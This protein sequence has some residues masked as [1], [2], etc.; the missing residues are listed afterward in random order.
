MKLADWLVLG[1]FLALFGLVVSGGVPENMFVLAAGLGLAFLIGLAAL[2]SM[3]VRQ[4]RIWPQPADLSDS[5]L[6]TRGIYQWIRHPM[7]L[8]VMTVGLTFV[9]TGFTWLRL[10]WFG[11]LLAVLQ[12]KM[13]YEERLLADK[14]PSYRQYCRLTKR[15]LPGIY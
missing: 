9:L 8:A 3:P 10:F 5:Q 2:I 4:W 7:Y 15:L 1:Q 11:V 6:V 14:F 13:V 12:H